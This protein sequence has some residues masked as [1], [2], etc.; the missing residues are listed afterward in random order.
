MSKP[1]PTYRSLKGELDAILIELQQEDTDVDQTLAKYKR[2]LELI[3][4]LETQLR[5]AENTI[6]ELKP[7]SS[8]GGA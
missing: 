4:Q 8:S 1:K 2:G 7:K 3:K 5:D 6:T